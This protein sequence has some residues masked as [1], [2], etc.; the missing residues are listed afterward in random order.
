MRLT[1][2]V[3]V[4]NIAEHL[5][6]FFASMENQSFTDY[7]LLMIDDGSEDNSLAVC[8]LY[9]EK[10]NRIQVLSLEHVGIAKARNIAM[11]H[12][13]T[14]F[15]AYADGDD[16][17]EPDY[18]KHLMD[19][20]E[21]HDADLSISRVQY[22]LEDGTVEAEFCSRG[23]LFIPKSDFIEQ[24][25]MLLN[26]RRLNYLY[27]KVYRSV[28]LKDIRVEDDVRQG[29]D[30]MINFQYLNN[31]DSIVLIDD[32]DY[33]YIRYSSRSVTS[34]SGEDAYFRISRINRYVYDYSEKMGI[35]SEKMLFIIDSR[36]LQSAIWVIDKIMMSN[37]DNDIKAKQITQILND[38]FYVAS[39]Q[40]QKSKD[41]SFA[42]DMIEPQDGRAYLN[43]RIREEKR[44]E[45]KAKILNKCPEFIVDLF[46]KIK[47]VN[48]TGE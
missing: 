38:S 15:T 48:P 1:V 13:H 43:K 18:L 36:V 19:A 25:P 23:E 44:N 27:G 41:D 4:Y 37:N 33:H 45:R 31:A 34:Y 21:K 6:R 17:V 22:M 24:I 40:R 8:N 3:T 10:D 47:G 42:F 16:Y 35:L 32:V 30:T 29:S 28:L 5:P 39:Y 26:D 7:V 2:I 14:E 12:I 20:V 11:E 9:A 46:H